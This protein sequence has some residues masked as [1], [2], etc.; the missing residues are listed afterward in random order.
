M[1]HCLPTQAR[2][3]CRPSERGRGAHRVALCLAGLLVVASQREVRT[4]PARQ[5]SKSPVPAAAFEPT[6]VTQFCV[7]CH[8]ERLK[9]AGFVLNP[10][11]LKDVGSRSEVW[12]KVLRKLRSGTM[13]PAGMPRPDDAA[14]KSF[15][16]WLEQRLEQAS[17]AHPNPG[18]PEAVHRLNR[19]EYQNAIRDLLD[20]DIEASTLLP[21]D[22]MDRHG[23]DNMAS[24]LSVSPALV[25]RYL[26]AAHKISRLAVGSDP[27]GA[28]S[29]D[30]YVPLDLAQGERLDEELPFG[31][32]GGIAVRHD[33]P[34]DGEYRIKVRLQR[35][36][37][38]HIRG[39]DRPHT[40]QV[41]FDGHLVKTFVV[42]GE[43]HGNPAPLSYAGNLLGDAQW[44]QYAHTADDGLEV[45][46]VAKAGP[47]I[48]G[49]AFIDSP[50]VSE[51]IP[52]PP[53]VGIGRAVNEG[54]DD[55]PMVG[56]VTIS[57]PYGAVAAGDTP[58]RRKVFACAPSRSTEEESCAR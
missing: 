43:Q 36:Y 57:G 22:D 52:Q 47:R 9:T 40:L 11:D 8:N 31:S 25:E 33:F 27:K 45:S 30:Y 6:T 37:V 35:A 17:A 28:S 4:A 39:L 42:G 50:W 41:R 24:V 23:F 16:T 44:E 34:V 46:L 58:S 26:S 55:D 38:E 21:A 51:G 15:V 10:A 3:A 54:A 5:A 32:R 13:P 2:P 7:T 12:E 1:S 53:L 49:A 20:L 19:A 56:Q 14:R 48:V 29:S 18:R